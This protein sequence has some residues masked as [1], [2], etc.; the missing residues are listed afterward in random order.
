MEKLAI[1]IRN[2]AAKT[3]DIED[4]VDGVKK[5][6]LKAAQQVCTLMSAHG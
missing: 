3:I 6:V 5:S 1:T 4:S 2:Q